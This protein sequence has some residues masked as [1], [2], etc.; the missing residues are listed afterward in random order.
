[1]TSYKTDKYLSNK[2]LDLFVNWILVINYLQNEI[3]P[4]IK[5]AVHT[6]SKW[7]LTNLDLL[8]YRLMG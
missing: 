7:Y 3:L 8:Q 6:F 5:A 2:T 1:M 4:Y